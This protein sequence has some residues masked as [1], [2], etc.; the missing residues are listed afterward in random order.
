MIED[1]L[2]Y[3][4]NDTLL[5]PRFKSL[6]HSIKV[7]LSILPTRDIASDVAKQSISDELERKNLSALILANFK[8][9]QESA[10][11]LEEYTKLDSSFGDSEVY[12]R[13]RYELYALEKAYFEKY[14]E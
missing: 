2:R 4:H 9:A 1:S 6:R 14:G 7:N 11:V 8:R 12:K 13:A 10:R 3:V 5:T